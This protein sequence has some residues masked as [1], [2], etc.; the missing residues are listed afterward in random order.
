MQ[1]V[2]AF[3]QSCLRIDFISAEKGDFFFFFD[4]L[5]SVLVLL[6]GYRFLSVYFFCHHQ[7]PFRLM[8]PDLNLFRLP[9]VMKSHLILPL[10]IYSTFPALLLS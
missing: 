4:G 6:S 10:R 7:N 5:Y 1:D 3:L 2:V 8:S 9:F